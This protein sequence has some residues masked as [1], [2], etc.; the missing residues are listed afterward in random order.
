MSYKNRITEDQRQIVHN[1]KVIRDYGEFPKGKNH[2]YSKY[3]SEGLVYMGNKK[4][5]GAGSH[6]REYLTSQS[7]VKLTKKGRRLAR[8]NE[9]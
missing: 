9:Y 4:T 5:I 3:K 2:L 1:L 8:V 7:K 6:K